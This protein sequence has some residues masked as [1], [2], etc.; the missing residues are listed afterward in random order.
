[1]MALYHRDVRGGTGQLIDVNLIEPLARLIES[2]TL[3]FDQLGIVPGR[4]GNRLDASAPRNAYRTSDDQWLAISSASPNIAMR[5]LPRHRPARAGRGPRLRR[6][7]PAAGA[8]RRGRRA[9]GRLGRRAHARRGDGGVRGG[10]GHRRA[11]LRRRAAAGRR[12]P[13]GPRVLRRGRRP[14]PR[15]DDRAGAGRAADARRRAASTTSAAPS[16]PTTTPC[17]ASSSALDAD[18]LAELR[19]AKAS[20]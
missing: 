2:S 17:S 1:M 16:A 19:A 15:P 12:A 14:R 8:G 11:R 13:P 5:V 3:S 9:R 4:V 20:I 7:R 6:S 18:R 10:R